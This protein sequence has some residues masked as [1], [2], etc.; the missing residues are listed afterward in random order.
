MIG[1]VPPE[2]E[3]INVETG[4]RIHPYGRYKTINFPEVELVSS[5]TDEDDAFIREVTIRDGE[6][7][8]WVKA[9]FYNEYGYELQPAERVSAAEFRAICL[10]Q[11]AMGEEGDVTV[12]EIRELLD[13]EPPA[14]AVEH[15][16]I[17]VYY[18][19]KVDPEVDEKTV[20]EYHDSMRE[21]TGYFDR[22]RI[23]PED[24]VGMLDDAIGCADE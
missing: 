5:V 10:K 14:E 21:K 6:Y 16:L 17:A 9:G 3:F 24:I 13:P 1:S 4:T 12:S 19:M 8:V 23:T 18:A 15:L 7:E 2:K 20:T 22:D 11:R